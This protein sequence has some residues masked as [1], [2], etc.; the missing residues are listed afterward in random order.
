[1][2]CNFNEYDY[3]YHLDT[4]GIYL[5]RHDNII[6][7]DGALK[8][9]KI[10]NITEKEIFNIKTPLN[11]DI[12]NFEKDIFDFRP[13]GGE[14][15]EVLLYKYNKINDWFLHKVFKV[16]NRHVY[17]FDIFY[18]VQKSKLW[19]IGFVYDIEEAIRS[20]ETVNLVKKNYIFIP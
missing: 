14:Y 10:N 18:E 9:W 4:S 15:I 7:L 19:N 5:K 1:M 20:G 12:D 2:T 6:Y 13:F 11:F 8:L 17:K 16:Y 3:T